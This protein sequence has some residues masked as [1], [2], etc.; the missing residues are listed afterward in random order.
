MSNEPSMTSFRLAGRGITKRFGSQTALEHVDFELAAGEVKGL[1]G[2]N[3]AGKSTLLKIL[4]GAIMPDEGHL[5]LNGKPVRMNSMWDANSR[6]IALV[7][8]ELSLFPS[9]S[10]RENLEIAGCNDRRMSRADRD[11]AAR[12][13]LSELGLTVSLSLPLGRLSLGDR[14]LVE[15]ARALLQEPQVLILDEPTS[16]LHEAE[17]R[18]LLE[19][20]KGVRARGVGVIYVSHFL[21]EV[22]EVA[23]ALVVLRDGKRVPADFKPSKERLP[24]LVSAMLGESAVSGERMAPDG[25]LDPGRREAPPAVRGRAKTGSLVIAG[26]KGPAHLSIPSWT[27]EPGKVIGVAGLIGSGVEE[28]FG[29]LFGRLRA[30]QGTIELPSGRYA[31]RSINQAVQSGVAYVPADRKR[32]GLM[33]EQSI[34]ENVSA[35]RSLVQQADGFFLSES[36]SDSLAHDRCAA[37][38]LQSRSVRQKV[39][40]LSG[41]NQQKVVFAKWLEA[42]PSLVLLDDPTRG[43]DIGAKREMHGIIRGLAEQGC[44]VLM[45]SSDPLELVNVCSRI[46]VFVNG[47]LHSRLDGDGLTEHALVSAMNRRSLK[48]EYSEL[49]AQ[50]V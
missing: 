2:A 1:L 9:L 5:L 40:A 20:I 46:H 11:N 17:K 42:K 37:L 49:E 24:E 13:A 15:I 10:V 3:G 25:C 19:V 47:M 16:A 32:I 27:I 45:H 35:V 41:G 50:A 4:A 12:S 39:G 44:V 23:D 43:V 6:G 21:E 28:L 33:I 36:R 30:S 31:P 14:Q 8:Q 22:L 26:L 48:R 18:R 38:R 7:S 34:A 29:I